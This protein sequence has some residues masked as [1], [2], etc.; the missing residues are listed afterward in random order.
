VVSDDFELLRAYARDGSEQAFETLVKRHVNLVYSAALRQ[1]GD[2]ALAS[3]V[4]Q[5]V[6][7]IL[8]RKAG[9]LSPRT[10][11]SGWLYRT[12]QFAGAHALRA[13]TRRRTRE[14]EALLMET[15]AT[16]SDSEWEQISPLLEEGMARLGE[17][18]RNAVVLRFFEKQS[19]RTVGLALGI[20]EDTAQKRVTRALEKLREYF[21]RRGVA[22]SVAAVGAALSAHAVHAAPACVASSAFAAALGSSGSAVST[23]L[24][25]ET[26]KFMA[27]TKAKTAIAGG[28]ALLLAG[29]IT[30]TILGL[31]HVTGLRK[32]AMNPLAAVLHK[33][34]IIIDEA[35]PE[36]AGVPSRFWAAVISPDGKTLATTGGG[37]N[38]PSE[39]GE[40]VLWDLAAGHEVLIRRQ[41]VTVRSMAFSHDGKRIAYGD[42]SGVTRVME[43]ATG[44]IINTL[45]NHQGIVNTV[46]FTPDDKSI[47]S[48]CFDGTITVWDYLTG[49]DEVGFDLPGERPLTAVLSPDNTRLMAVTWEGN[50]Y[51]W[52]FA[53]RRMLYSIRATRGK[54]MVEGLV[55]AP[56]GKTFMTGSRDSLLRIWDTK[57]G[58]SV[59]DLTGGKTI[60]TEAIYSPDG[61]LL[62]TGGFKGDLRLWSP[63]TGE[64]LNTIDAHGERFYGLVLTPDGKRLITAGW[65]YKVIIWN[66]ETLQPV[67]TLTRAVGLSSNVVASS[68]TSR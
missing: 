61:T 6:F 62:F 47:I 20:N 21:Q 67:A 30:I 59:R 41:P 27:W 52:D 19:W 29:A 50:G 11:L 37:Y 22:L 42:F 55:F 57:T 64:L 3:E 15:E 39:A 12:A 13:E 24:L 26:L 8:A 44:K 32:A 25:N 65:D 58:E 63:A 68:T 14:Q 53:T 66:A 9:T 17:S 33:G 16:E 49:K 48:A 1:V 18:D 54:A 5:T 28:V 51:A 60:V 38:F 10:I 43:G 7:I 35:A 45:S 31:L 56:D 36:S 2:T 23:P 46:L 40:L 4:V 34:P